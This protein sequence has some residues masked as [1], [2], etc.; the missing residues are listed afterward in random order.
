MIVEFLAVSAMCGFSLFVLAG[1]SAL[2]L[3]EAPAAAVFLIFI[4]NFDKNCITE[5]VKNEFK[6]QVNR[7]CLRC[8]G[9]S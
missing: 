6:I 8:K 1:L 2:S 9:I 3:T 5:L 4:Y 7:P